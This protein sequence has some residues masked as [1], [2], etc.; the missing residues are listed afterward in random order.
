MITIKK[1]QSVP[2]GEQLEL[3]PAPSYLEG[4]RSK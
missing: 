1:K 2:E 3:L 4:S